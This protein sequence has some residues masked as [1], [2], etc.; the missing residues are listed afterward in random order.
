MTG[1]LLVDIVLIGAI[2][3]FVFG[4]IFLLTNLK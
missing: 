4:A 1:V 2:A 3:W